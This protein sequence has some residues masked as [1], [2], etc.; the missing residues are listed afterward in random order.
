MKE[1]NGHQR[2]IAVICVCCNQA[3]FIGLGRPQASNASGIKAGITF[4][5]IIL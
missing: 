4:T 2:D 1:K 3:N 5:I